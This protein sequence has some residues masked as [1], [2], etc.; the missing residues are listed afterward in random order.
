ML[1]S[2]EGTTLN[3]EETVEETVEET[4]E[5]Y[6]DSMDTLQSPCSTSLS[7]RSY[8]SLGYSSFQLD[9]GKSWLVERILV[10]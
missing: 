5:G 10:H 1:R 9:S 2:S 3:H 7:I 4:A 8:S 6:C